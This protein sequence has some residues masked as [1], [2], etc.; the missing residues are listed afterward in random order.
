MWDIAK[1]LYALVS[2]LGNRSYGIFKGEI[3]KCIGTE[4]KLHDKMLQLGLRSPSKLG[5]LFKELVS[6]KE[7]DL[8]YFCLAETCLAHLSCNQGN[9]QRI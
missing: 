1:N 2:G 7:C 5:R 8:F 9:A 4:C 3:L 6:V